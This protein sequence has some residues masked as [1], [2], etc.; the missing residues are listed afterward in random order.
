MIKIKLFNIKNIKMDDNKIFFVDWLM[1]RWKTLF[2]LLICVAD[3]DIIYTN[4]KIKKTP[5]W[6]KIIEIKY[7]EEIEELSFRENKSKKWALIIDEAQKLLNRRLSNT[8]T[9]RIVN[10]FSVL[11]RKANLDMFLI[12]QVA[13]RVDSQLLELSSNKI[14]MK[15]KERYIN[16]FWFWDIAVNYEVF[17]KSFNEE[18]WK[19][20]RNIT[21]LETET[22]D[23]IFILKK[24]G[25]EYDTNDIAEIKLRPVL[26]NDK[27]D[28]N[29]E[30]EIN[31]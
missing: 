19:I 3:Y 4:I 15:Q 17:E 11:S 27:K 13:W 8:K 31:I 9:N 29:D 5:Y 14:N 22:R 21:T 28:K 25:L 30:F 16:K 18:T 10:N 20:I 26:K 1:G 2:T 12:P 7:F 24:I 6:K 23:T